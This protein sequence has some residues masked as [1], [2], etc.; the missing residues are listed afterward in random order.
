VLLVPCL[1]REV[2]GVIRNRLRRID[3][4]VLKSWKISEL[5]NNNDNGLSDTSDAIHTV[6]FRNFTC[7]PPGNKMALAL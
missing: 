1:Q 3:S 4:W 5:C 2:A 6:S 7:E